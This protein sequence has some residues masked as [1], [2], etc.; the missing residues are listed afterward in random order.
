[1]GGCLWPLTPGSVP[2]LRLVLEAEKPGSVDVGSGIYFRDTLVGRI[3]SRDFF[4][5]E[6]KV[7]FG[8]FF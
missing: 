3:E 2:G 1:M 7:R 5:E 4:P 6:K 8:A